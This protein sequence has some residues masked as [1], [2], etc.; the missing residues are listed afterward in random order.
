MNSELK[1]KIAELNA[2]WGD[3][4]DDVPMHLQAIRAL[5]QENDILKNSELFWKN[6]A[7]LQC[8]QKHTQAF[9]LRGAL[10]EIREI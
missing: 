1:A 7:N 10:E 8:E 9:V 5:M 4:G 3:A 6:Q 2:E